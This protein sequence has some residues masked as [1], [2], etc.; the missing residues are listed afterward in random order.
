MAFVPEKWADEIKAGTP[1]GRRAAFAIARANAQEKATVRIEAMP[2]VSTKGTELHQA[3]EEA[4][5]GP[6]SCGTCIVFLH[7][8]DRTL[9]YDVAAITERLLADLPIP[10]TI[11]EVIGTIASQR[12]WIRSIVEKVI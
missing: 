7:S 12:L 9:V 1:F 4:M 5:G 11:R 6:I 10:I 8:L 2:R 3:L